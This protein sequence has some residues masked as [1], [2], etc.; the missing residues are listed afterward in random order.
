[1]WQEFKKFA[2]KGNVVD[3][4]VA[5]IIGG[6]FNK[7]VKSLVDN[8]LMPLVGT[9]LGGVSF[10]DLKVTVGDA[11]IL[12]GVFIQSVVDFFIIAFSI[13]VFVKVYRKLERK[14]EQKGAKPETQED[15]LRQIRDLLR[16]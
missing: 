7:I 11:E 1:M 16:Q 13:F 9:L 12:Y 15:L 3:L 4:A 5:V 6:A 10:E 8:I 2:L 14:E